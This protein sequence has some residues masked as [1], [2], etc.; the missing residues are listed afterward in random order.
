MK[1]AYLLAKEIG[2][3]F[4]TSMDV[5]SS[6][7]LLIESQTKL[8]FSKRLKREEFLEILKWAR[9]EYPNEENP[10]SLR[11]NFWGE[12]IGEALVSGWTYETKKYTENLTTRAIR[13]KS[14]LYG[15]EK[16]LS[17]LVEILL[18]DE[19]NNVLLVGESGVGKDALVEAFA[20]H[21]KIGLSTALRAA[22]KAITDE[23]TTEKK[24]YKAAEALDVVNAIS[25]YWEAIRDD[26]FD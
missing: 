21:T 18:K 13:K 4:V 25:N 9:S 14:I 12:G 23:L 19:N 16:E 20:Y 5:F 11:V 3:K 24:L 8:L 1:S 15:R 6:Y 10:Q 26:R 2:G 7:I 17:S 22:R